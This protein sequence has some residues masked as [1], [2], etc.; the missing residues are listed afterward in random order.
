MI[1]SHAFSLFLVKFSLKADYII[2]YQNLII[3]ILELIKNLMQL[4]IIFQSNLHSF[5]L[6]F[7]ILRF[8]IATDQ[9]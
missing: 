4:M 7:I 1:L 2:F 5:I 8:F 6:I 9:Q 3:I